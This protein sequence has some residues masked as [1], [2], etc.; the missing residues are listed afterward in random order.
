EISGEV[1]PSFE[2]YP[3]R[4]ITLH[5]ARKNFLSGLDETLGPAGLLSFKSGHLYRQLGRALDVLQ[6][7]K[8]PP[9]QLSTVRQ[10]GVFG[11]RVVLPASRFFNGTASPYSG[12]PIE[13][14][15]DIAAGSSRMFQHEMPVQEYRFYLG[16]EG[17]IAVDMSPP[18]LYHT[19]LWI[20]EMV[21]GS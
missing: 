15:K 18:R 14:E 7:D 9:L 1:I 3:K 11:Q 2:F 17:I 16:Q 20:S 19:D 12:C 8:F 5:H 13:I 4:L 10:V 21:D 6:I